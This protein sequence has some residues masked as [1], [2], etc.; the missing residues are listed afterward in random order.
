MSRGNYD[1]MISSEISDREIAATRSAAFSLSP[2]ETF[3][4]KWITF[5]PRKEGIRTLISDILE[6]GFL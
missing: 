3:L 2:R 6:I 4:F 1:E 5:L